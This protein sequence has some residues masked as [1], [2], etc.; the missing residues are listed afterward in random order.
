[1]K[2]AVRV[3]VRGCEDLRVFHHPAV[4]PMQHLVQL[5]IILHTDDRHLTPQIHCSRHVTALGTLLQHVTV[6]VFRHFAV[7]GDE[8]VELGLGHR[9]VTHV[10]REAGLLCGSLHSFTVPFLTSLALALAPFPLAL[11]AFTLSI[12]ASSFALAALPV[13]AALS[14]RTTHVVKLSMWLKYRDMRFVV[15]RPAPA[16]GQGRT[17]LESVWGAG[18]GLPLCHGTP[19]CRLTALS[20]MRPLLSIIGVHTQARRFRRHIDSG[21]A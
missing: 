14:L 19:E 15:G 13:L 6:V 1:V 10:V 20:I 21:T 3:A 17:V 7:R 18:T 11:A 4:E 12:L 2:V 9:V 5:S 16:Q 8:R